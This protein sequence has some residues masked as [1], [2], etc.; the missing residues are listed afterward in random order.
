MLSTIINYLRSF[1]IEPE[2]IRSD[3]FDK[4]HYLE[5]VMT[6]DGQRV[7]NRELGR[8]EV[9]RLPWPEGFDFSYFIHLY[10][11]IFGAPIA[12]TLDFDAERVL[13]PD[14]L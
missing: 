5:Y 2:R 10:K 12:S 1:G 8:N 3:V 7:Y 13:P 14:G 9:V 4:T 11:P 6:D